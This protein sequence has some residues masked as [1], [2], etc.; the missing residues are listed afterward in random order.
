[1]VGTSIAR[2]LSAEPYCYPAFKVS[3]T[4][5]ILR[6]TDGRPY[7]AHMLIQGESIPSP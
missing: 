4:P 3:A 6:T 2:P 7:G 1:M 5:V